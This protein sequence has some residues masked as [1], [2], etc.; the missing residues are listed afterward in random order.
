MRSTRS[1]AS[2]AI[3]RWRMDPTL[4]PNPVFAG[5]SPTRPRDG[6]P[7]L[8]FSCSPAC[9]TCQ[10]RSRGVYLG[11]YLRSYGRRAL[12]TPGRWRRAARRPH[13]RSATVPLARVDTTS[14]PTLTGVGLGIRRALR[15]G[16]TPDPRLTRSLVRLESCAE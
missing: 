15:G 3:G 14:V 13:P 16:L 6:A 5:S 4:T 1:W 7:A 8:G 2:E 9:Q 11:A 10:A 12:R